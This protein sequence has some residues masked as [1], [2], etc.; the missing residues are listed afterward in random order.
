MRRWAWLG[1][2]ALALPVRAEL[3][4]PELPVPARAQALGGAFAN[5]RGTGESLWYNPAGLR[6]D[7]MEVQAG[8]L[9]W[10]EGLQVQGILAAAGY[11][12]GGIGVGLRSFSLQE[13]QRDA[14]GQD[15]GAFSYDER[16]LSA[17][18]A[19]GDRLF[20]WGLA[21]RSQSQSWRGGTLVAQ[22]LDRLYLDTGVQAA[23]PWAGWR[24]AAYLRGFSWE[25][26]QHPCEFGC[27]PE[28]KGTL[29][30]DRLG[31]EWIPGVQGLSLMAETAYYPGPGEWTLQ[32]GA[33]EARQ[34][35]AG[36]QGALRVGWRSDQSD[37]R[38]FAGLSAGLGLARD[39][40]ALDYAMN[41][42]GDFGLAHR[43]SL[44]VKIH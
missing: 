17:G 42:L 15:L 31:L 43:L 18:V 14:L 13:E 39:W 9:Q 16:S 35:G 1:L 22:S 29:P 32:A 41:S 23:L 37:L 28:V 34:I 19:F 40:L 20:A 44:V 24:G 25:T 26:Q 10:A 4:S 3:R 11:G 7:Y 21:L 6:G 2:V 5:G 27:F 8:V 38:G 30:E 33:E 12:K 36:V